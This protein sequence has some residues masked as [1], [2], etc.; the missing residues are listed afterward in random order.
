MEFGV[1]LFATG[2]REFGLFWGS[3]LSFYFFLYCNW[4]QVYVIFRANCSLERSQEWEASPLG[5]ST[6]QEQSNVR[7]MSR[8]AVQA[9]VNKKIA[10]HITLAVGMVMDDVSSLF[11]FKG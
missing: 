8:L 7:E 3:L 1:L 2:D 9:S 10:Q 5:S 4:R 11:V 6:F